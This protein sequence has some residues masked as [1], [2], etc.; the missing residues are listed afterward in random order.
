MSAPNVMKQVLMSP[1]YFAVTAPPLPPHRPASPTSPTTTLKNSI[2][3]CEAALNESQARQKRGKKDSKATNL[4]LRKEID[5]LTGKIAKIGGDD[6]A[7][8]SRHLQWNQHMR[9]ADK[10]V[11]AI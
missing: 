3:A 5:S 9:Q 7:Q 6:K 8:T 4:S 1:E 2:S 11:T 10:A